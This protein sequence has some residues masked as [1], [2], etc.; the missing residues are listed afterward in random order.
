MVRSPPVG[1]D[2]GLSILAGGSK[3]IETAPHFST[4]K[5]ERIART[6]SQSPENASRSPATLVWLNAH[7]LEASLDDSIVPGR[8]PN[9]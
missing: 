9:G 1:A 6:P 7:V 8:D 4:T 2:F 3:S 5:H